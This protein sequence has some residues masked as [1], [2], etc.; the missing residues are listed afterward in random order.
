MK[1]TH[2]SIEDNRGVLYPISLSE[3]PF[4]VKRVFI[5]TNV[6]K[7]SVRG[8]HAH[9]ECLQYYLCLKGKIEII[10]K[11]MC[12]TKEN[13]AILNEGQGVFID[14]GRWTGEIF[15]TGKDVLMV[16]CS[17]EYDKNDYIK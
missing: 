10:Y 14:K 5:V 2:K 13:L 7:G 4:E 6:P 3:I 17:H 11:D 16:F 1:I 12:G 15:L 9:K 8:E